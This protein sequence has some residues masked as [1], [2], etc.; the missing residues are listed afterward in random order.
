MAGVKLVSMMVAAL[1]IGSAHLA[2]AADLPLKA[3]PLSVFSWTGFY[4]GGSFG[5]D[6]GTA[7]ATDILA[8]NGLAWVRNGAQWSAKIR[9]FTA[10][11]EAGYNWQVGNIVFGVEGDVGYLG[12]TGSSQY[13]LLTTTTLNT[14]GNLFS[15]ARGRFGFAFD[16]VLVYGTGGWFGADFDSTVNQS[17][18]VVIHTSSTG[19][20]SGWTAGGGLEWAFARNWSLKGE[21]LHYDVGTKKVGGTFTGGGAAIQFFNIKDTGD[22]ARAGINYHF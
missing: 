9:S 11:A 19:F 18:G 13:P 14:H 22:I 3:P 10:S 8:T 2:S 5:G 16:R 7:T 4:V 6:S 12:Q 20:Q 1:S 21:F 15:T 17:I